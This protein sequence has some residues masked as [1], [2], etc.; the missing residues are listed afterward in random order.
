[1]VAAAGGGREEVG[2]D[3]AVEREKRGTGFRVCLVFAN[4]C[5]Q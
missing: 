5:K 1:M 2:V 4:E 3:T